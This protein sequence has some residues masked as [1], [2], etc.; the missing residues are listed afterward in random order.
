MGDVEI[1]EDGLAYCKVCGYPRQSRVQFPWGVQ[2]PRCLCLCEQEQLKREQAEEKERRRREIIR[3]NRREAFPDASYLN[4]TFENADSDNLINIAHR[5]VDNFDKLKKTGQG[6][7]FLGTVGCGKTYASACIVNALVEK[8][9][10]CRFTSFADILRDAN[11][12]EE[13]TH[14]DLVVFDDF[15]VERWTDYSK[16]IV[17]SVINKLYVANVSCI[18]SSNITINEFNQPNDIATARITSRL[19]ERCFPVVSNHKDRRTAK[20]DD[21]KNLLGID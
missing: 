14:Y 1:R 21:I 12:G 13:L 8:G 17:C 11:H 9:Y 2:T 3:Q 7:I 16:E 4:M 5:F 20:T 19:K 18:L 15:G 10:K 6:L